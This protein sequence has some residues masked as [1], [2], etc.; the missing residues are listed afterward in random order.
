MTA[1]RRRVARARR[2]DSSEDCRFRAVRLLTVRARSRDELRRALELRGFDGETIRT[3]LDALVRDGSLN[4]QAAM[5][6]FLVNREERFSRERL[7][8]EMRQRGFPKV[9]I[10]RALAGISDDDERTLL[11]SLCRR[12]FDELADLPPEKRKKKVFD[13]LRRR[14]FGAPQ[15]LETMGEAE[16]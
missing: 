8:A 6:S 13:F 4:E 5:E 1:L 2:P 11:E 10:D 9:S 12:R 3:T 7:R 15:I 14:G 16:D